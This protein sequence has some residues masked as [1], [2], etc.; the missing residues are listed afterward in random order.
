MTTAQYGQKCNSALE[1]ARRGKIHERHPRVG[2][3]A[4]T[5]GVARAL[6]LLHST[7]V[8]TS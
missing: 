4:A 3:A 5:L 8:A 1:G 2:R 6:Q 7:R